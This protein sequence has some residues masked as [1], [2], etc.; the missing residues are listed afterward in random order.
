[1]G[2][3]QNLFLIELGDGAFDLKGGRLSR[4]SLKRFPR[5]SKL[6]MVFRHVTEGAVRVARQRDLS[7]ICEGAVTRP[8]MHRN[9]STPSLSFSTWFSSEGRD[10]FVG[11]AGGETCRTILRYNARHG[12]K[13]M[14]PVSAA[15]CSK[16]KQALAAS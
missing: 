5:E 6:E 10:S 13:R 7:R 3:I 9:C 12:A 14:N 16:V 11:L 1:M 15:L 2:Q 4:I 8:K